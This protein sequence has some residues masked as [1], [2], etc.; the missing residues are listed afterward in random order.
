MS[1]HENLLAII[2]KDPDTPYEIQESFL[3]GRDEISTDLPDIIYLDEAYLEETEEE[4]FTYDNY[5]FHHP[6]RV[7][8]IS[9]LSD[10]DKIIMVVD[11]PEYSESLESARTEALQTSTI[12]NS[13]EGAVVNPPVDQ[14]V[15]F[16]STLSLDTEAVEEEPQELPEP[17][18]PTNLGE[19]VPFLSVDPKEYPDE[20]ADF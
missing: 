14:P 1:K 12:F 9:V 19:Q 18:V 17:P 6:D 7:Y 20:I 13:P 5:V 3:L 15:P 10:G 4:F 11:T 16:N 2:N 8:N